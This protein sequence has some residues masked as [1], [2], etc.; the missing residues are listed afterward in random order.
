MSHTQQGQICFEQMLWGRSAEMV[1]ARS[2]K[3][4][5]IVFSTPENLLVEITI[6]L[7]MKGG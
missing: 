7:R 5:A 4:F 2:F 3:H 1:S 6:A